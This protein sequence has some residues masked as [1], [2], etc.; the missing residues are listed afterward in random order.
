M[1]DLPGEMKPKPSRT[2]LV[3][4]ATG[5]IGTETALAL[6]R[7]GWQIRAFSRATNP[8]SESPGWQWVKG[9]ALNRASVLTAA[10]GVQAIVHA[11]NP[12][13]YRNWATLVL[14]MIDNTIAAAKASGA[15]ILLPG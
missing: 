8:H 11:V 9:D 10:E 15:R 1:K 6:S 3:L 13:G 7:H 4:G 5:G 14:P 2:A 12:P